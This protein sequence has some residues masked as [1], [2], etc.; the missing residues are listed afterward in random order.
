MYGP[1]G[2][3]KLPLL[4][5][6]TNINPLTD[7]GFIFL[8]A[9]RLREQTTRNILNK[10]SIF[11]IST[12]PAHLVCVCVC[13]LKLFQVAVRWRQQHWRGK[14]LNGR[15]SSKRVVIKRQ[16]SFKCTIRSR[17]REIRKKRGGGGTEKE[18]SRRRKEGA[19][20][21]WSAARRLC[22]PCVPA[23]RKQARQGKGKRTHTLTVEVHMQ[24]YATIPQAEVFIEHK[25]TLY[26]HPRD[27]VR[28]E[29]SARTQ[30]PSGKCFD[31]EQQRTNLS[32]MFS[33]QLG[34]KQLWTHFLNLCPSFLIFH[35][36]PF[37]SA[38]F[39]AALNDFVFCT[40]KALAPL[41]GTS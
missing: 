9:A 10:S 14:S 5:Q 35:C 26:A 20:L 3:S 29:K 25:N 18:Q 12:T 6:Q 4:R 16:R 11:C 15:S 30:A 24:K 23:W 2:F 17:R 22:G 32:G 33:P 41:Q 28:H 21:S 31:S 13:A 19:R 36:L 37:R 7:S 38:F 40:L 34:A 1:E 8:P 27:P 39:S